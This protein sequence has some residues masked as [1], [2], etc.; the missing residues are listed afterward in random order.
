MVRKL[1]LS[2][3]LRA[4]IVVSET[5]NRIPMHMNAWQGA[6]IVAAAVVMAVL[7][8]ARARLSTI[9]VGIALLTAGLS[10][11]LAWP[12][13]AAVR[14]NFG[15]NVSVFTVFSGTLAAVLAIGTITAS[16][17][18]VARR[19]PDAS[20]SATDRRTYRDILPALALP[21]VCTAMLTG[22]LLLART[23]A[24]HSV[25]TAALGVVVALAAS[26]T[27]LPALVGLG[28]SSRQS[29]SRTA[30]AAWTSPLSIPRPA[31]VTIVVLAI[32][33]L[34]VIGMRWSLLQ[35]PANQDS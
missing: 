4:R 11:A 25:G 10:L 6:M 26:L 17:S 19:L 9:F 35:N 12:L 18:L 22:P 27:L 2:S 34:P 13:A 23:P 7:L 24:L 33:A 32:C 5:T 30:G 28:G 29:P 20:A 15:A 8:L 14:G 16:T 31:V 21:G 3:G 1:P